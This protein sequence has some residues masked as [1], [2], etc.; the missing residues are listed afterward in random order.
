MIWFLS[1][2]WADPGSKDFNFK[3]SIILTMAALFDQTYY[4]I[5]GIL[6]NCI[7]I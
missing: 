1:M 4:L 3:I 6:W 2:I 7:T 5:L